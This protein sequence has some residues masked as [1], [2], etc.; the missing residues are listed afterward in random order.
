MK[1]SWVYNTSQFASDQLLASPGH[2]RKLKHILVDAAS[3][4]P[5]F[6]SPSEM[7]S[8][9]LQ[10]RQIASYSVRGLL[11][12]LVA[13]RNVVFTLARMWEALNRGNRLGDEDLSLTGG[14]TRL[15]SDS[16]KREIRFGASL[17]HG[18]TYRV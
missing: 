15:D 1:D 12:A 18:F 4:E 7:D 10:D 9:V 2:I 14:S 13:E 11:V 5:T 8:I 6:F 17:V 3:M 16:S